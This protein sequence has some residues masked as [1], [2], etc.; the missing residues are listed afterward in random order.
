MAGAVR[1]KEYRIIAMADGT[2]SEY[3]F[4]ATFDNFRG[5]HREADDVR[6][7]VVDAKNGTIKLDMFTSLG[8]YL[9]DNDIIALN[10]VGIGP[11]RLLGCDEDFKPVDVCFLLPTIASDPTVWDVV[12]LAER[13]EPPQRG[14]LTLADGSIVLDLLGKSLDFDGSYWLEKDKYR[15]YR[16]RAK[17][18]QDV[19][20]LERT[21]GTSGLLMH[22]WY[23]DL[24]KLDIKKL[25][26]LTTKNRA[27]HPSEPARRLTGAMRA[28]FLTRGIKELPL[29]L[30]MNFS[31]RQATPKTRLFD[32]KM[33]EEE[34]E[35]SNSSIELLK[36][37][38]EE[39]RRVICAG[40]SAA[41]TLESLSIPPV[42]S[43]G[44]TDIFISPGFQFKYCS[45]LLTNLHNPMGTHVI[46]ACA[47]GGREL[48]IEACELAVRAGMKFGIHGDSMLVLGRDSPSAWS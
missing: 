10:E 23:A 21:L 30:V 32:Y 4:S 16:G 35:I 18:H 13:R 5:G 9:K 36:L 15:G 8:S 42:A 29:S 1:N 27:I 44:R 48:V 3:T 31:W 46:M 28:K 11:S 45:G 37:S 47:F 33:N 7:I 25:N 26:P 6:L 12:V 43:A 2:F 14:K 39:K 41:R 24:N 22:P 40:T 34:F 19:A 17:L 20:T 38:I